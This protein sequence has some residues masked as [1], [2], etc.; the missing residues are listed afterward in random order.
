MV[1][2]DGSEVL[3]VVVCNCMLPD[4]GLFTSIFIYKTMKANFF[5]DGDGITDKC[6]NCP[7]VYN[8]DQETNPSSSSKQGRACTP[9]KQKSLIGY[10]KLD[11]TNTT[12]ILLLF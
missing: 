10:W 4:K 7:D 8:R 6:D 1:D 11:D 3:N 12:S 5:L 9:C 2:L